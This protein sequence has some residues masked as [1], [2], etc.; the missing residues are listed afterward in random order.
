MIALFLSTSAL[1]VDGIE[2]GGGGGTAHTLGESGGTVALGIFRPWTLALNERTDLVTTGIVGTI[3]APRLDV[4][5]ALV[6]EETLSV[7]VEGGVAVPS[8]A[9]RLARGWLYTETEGTPFALIARAGVRVTGDAEHF[10]LTGSVFLRGGFATGELT[11]RDLFFLDWALAPAAEGPV[12]ATV[13]VRG[14]WLVTSRT[15]LSL[16]ATVQ[17]GGEGVVEL[18]NRA[19][20]LW[21]F[22]EHAALGAGYFSHLDARPDGYR[23]YAIPTG[24][25]QLRF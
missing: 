19:F 11:P 15:Q 3:L 16:E 25:V 2:V 22:S 6:R 24:D 20:A 8:P 21:G 9:L 18:Q 1:A 17:L 23:F 12:L 10:R 13:G 14:D 5:H 4:K 7:A